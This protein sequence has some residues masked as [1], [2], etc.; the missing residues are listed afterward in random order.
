METILLL[1]QSTNEYEV[2]IVPF[3]EMWGRLSFINIADAVKYPLEV[4]KSF[5][6]D[7]IGFMAQSANLKDFVN[8]FGRW[9]DMLKI[10]LGKRFRDYLTNECQIAH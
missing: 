10:E 6:R 4:A 8:A 2:G 1:L 9:D 7:F 3:M 5:S